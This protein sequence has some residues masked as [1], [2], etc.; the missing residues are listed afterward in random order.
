MMTTGANPEST[1][2]HLA[3]SSKVANERSKNASRTRRTTGGSQ[4]GTPNDDDSRILK[5][6]SRSTNIGLPGCE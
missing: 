1:L 6:K 4:R 5:G 3:R 2:L